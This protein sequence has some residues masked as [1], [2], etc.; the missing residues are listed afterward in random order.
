M[1]AG[2]CQYR[3]ILRSF[4]EVVLYWQDQVLDAHLAHSGQKPGICANKFRMPQNTGK[5]FIQL[6]YPTQVD[7]MHGTICFL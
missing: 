1:L 6:H 2:F 4:R 7:N 5:F 3:D